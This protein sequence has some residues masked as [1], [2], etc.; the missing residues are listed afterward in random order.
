MVAVSV[1]CSSAAYSPQVAFPQV[2]DA[3]KQKASQQLGPDYILVGRIITRVEKIT[4]GG[5]GGVSLQVSASG[6]WKYQFTAKSK[7]AMAKYISGTTVDKA[8]SW[9]KQQQ[10]VANVSLSVSG[11]FL[12]LG[13]SNIVPDD[14]GAITING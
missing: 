9:L 4:Q 7:L 13:S 14:P 8:K 2:E 5:Y 10:G 3:L 12:N 6:T 1:T 11:P